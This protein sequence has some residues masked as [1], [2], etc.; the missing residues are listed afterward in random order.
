MV[1]HDCLIGILYNYE[2]TQ[3]AT[4]FGLKEHIKDGKRLQQ[5]EKELGI[6]PSKVYSLSDY[7]DRRK[8]TDLFR[9]NYC[10]ICA[11]KIEWDKIK[12]N[13]TE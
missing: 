4:V 1:G 2:S 11:K 5:Y 7:C 3:T 13:A 10:P 12:Q 6:E 9:F 8:S